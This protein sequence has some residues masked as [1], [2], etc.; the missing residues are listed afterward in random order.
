M[1]NFT[2]D[3]M[4]AIMDLTT[5]IRNM[6]VIAHVDH[7][8]STLTD[9]LVC[10]AGIIS[11]E[12]A[13]TARFTD[14]RADE[15]ERG[16]TI[17]STGV[18]MYF[19]YDLPTELKLDAEDAEA[20]AEDA[21]AHG[22]AG[23]AAAPAPA[24]ADTTAAGAGTAAAGAGTAAAG[25]GA[26]T[27]VA[28]VA[29]AESAVAEEAAKLAE[30]TGVKVTEK[31]FLIN[32]IDSPG[33]V[34]FSS[35]V[36]AALRVTDGAL[37]VVD[38]IEGVCVQTETVL[39]QAIGERIRP[40][41]MLNKV[42]RCIM[43]LQ[44]PPEEA[45]R[46]FV[47][48]I[49]NVNVIISTYHDAALGDIQLDPTK[50]KVAFGS[51]LHQW[52]FT[53]KK[54][55]KIYAG[56]FGIPRFKMM[57]RLWGD[58][59]YNKKG[60][61]K[62]GDYSTDKEFKRGYVGMILDPIY[63]MF[64]AMLNDKKEK[65]DKMMASLGIVLKTD[66]KDLTGKALL[67]K[68][69]QK[70][71][72]AGDA[73]L[74]MIVLHLPSPREAQAYRTD[75]LYEGPL[76]DPLAIAMRKCDSH[77]PLM[78]F[79]S[80]MVPTADP[81][82]FYAFGRVFSGKI[83]TGQKVRIMGPNY[84]P[85]KHT[86]LWVKNIQRTVIMMGAKAEAVNDIPAGNTCGLVGVD[87]Y[88][89]KTG[90]LSDHDEAHSIRTMK[91]SVSP[92]VRVAVEVKNSAD[93]PKLVEGLKRLSKSDPLVQIYSNEETG[94]NIVAGAGEL[95]LEICLKDLADDFMKGAPIKISD[96]VVSFRE[97]VREK[98]S[99]VCLAKSPNKHNR[100]FGEAH[101][102]DEKLLVDIEEGVII[103]NPKEPKDQAKYI[104]EK[105]GFDADDV[106]PKKLW[107]FGPDGTGANWCMDGTRAVQYL[108]EIKDSICNAFQVATKA[109]P[110]CEEACRGII[111]KVLD[112]TLHADSIHRG[113]GQI[114]PAARKL[115]YACVYTASPT[116]M[117]PMYLAEITVPMS[118]VGGVYS[119]L[120]LRRGEIVEEIPR[121]GTPM[122]NIRAYLPVNESF[123]FTTALRAATGG[124]AFPQ[125][126]FHHW[127][128]MNGDPFI[129]GKVGDI[130]TAIRTRKGLKEMPPL[131]EYLDTM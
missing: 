111:V 45:Y 43:E 10:K 131:S 2:V 47:K 41:L 115:I 60:E 64:D 29:A 121:A 70:W 98:S 73:I 118:D 36:T 46:N 23:D 95:H 55:A 93:L 123:G 116:L 76:D 66:E 105:Y 9:A 39:R 24:A 67:K 99:Q 128:G 114:M 90:T 22:G 120:S 1:V 51:G 108:S 15:A 112:V 3:Q 104:A 28:A 86:D 79:V 130:V 32:L 110:L 88:L 101:P 11:A 126:S 16:I 71:L 14:N 69:M 122:T 74:E 54:F 100:L 103:P 4:R 129:A 40:V 34:D 7:G 75:M 77:G 119:T 68:V 37:V 83:A 58:M 52:G 82:R 87:Q 17:K 50:G 53:L 12:K 85:G 61:W 20:A 19:E 33:H 80:K 106:M 59:F 31:S 72:P 109:G 81:G 56:K 57:R 26:A 27:T 65:A 38:C 63:Q 125:C 42:D 107:A 113:M 8:K 97:T 78:M 18:S 94:E 84:T 44:L 89:I 5:N 117:E 21:K 6:S 127:S 124:K 25:A 48:S 30:E 62:K 102:M 96:P 13:G 92:V 91:F 35:E 49:E